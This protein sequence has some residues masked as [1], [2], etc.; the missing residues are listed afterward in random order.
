V[1][2]VTVVDDYAHHPTEIQVT[3]RAAASTTIRAEC[4]GLSTAPALTDRFLSRTSP[5]S[6]GAADMVLVPE[7]YFVRDT[8]SERELIDSK[9]LVGAI[10]MHGGDAR[11]EPDFGRIVATLADQVEDGDSWSPWARGNVYRWRMRCW[12]ICG[13]PGARTETGGS[14]EL[15]LQTTREGQMEGPA[16]PGPTGLAAPAAQFNRFGDGVFVGFP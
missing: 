8:E 5:V 14:E 1:A 6:F 7:I 9:V 11:Y 4:R 10:H 16:R 12:I 13:A 2:G 15:R 3:L